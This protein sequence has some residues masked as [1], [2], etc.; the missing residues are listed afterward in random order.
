M[1]IVVPRKDTFYYQQIKK[2][3]GIVA[4]YIDDEF[5]LIYY[6]GNLYGAENL[7][8]YT[9]RIRCAAGRAFENYPTIARTCV[10]KRRFKKEFI[11]IGRIDRDYWISLDI[12]ANKEN[13]KATED[14]FGEQSPVK[15]S[16]NG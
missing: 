15:I 3:S 16:E 13:Q 9:E 6:E 7:E 14:W 2:G 8:D 11:I 12:L 5:V 1:D 4:K 10:E